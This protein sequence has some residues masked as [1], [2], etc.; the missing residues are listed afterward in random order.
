[1]TEKEDINNRVVKAGL[2]AISMR[3]S[4]R[5]LGVLSTLILVRI[6]IPED[7][8][9]VAMAMVV[10]GIATVLLEFGVNMAIIQNSNATKDFYNSAWTLRIFQSTVAAI[11]LALAAPLAEKYF[12]EPRIV[13]VLYVISFSVFIGGFENIG[14]VAFQKHLDFAKD[15]KFLVIKK[16]STVVITISLAFYL[17]SYWSLVIG[18]LSGSILGVGFSYVIS[19]Y[20]PRISFLE[21][22]NLWSF[23][24]WILIRNIGA[25]LQTK[26]DQI[27]I[28]NRFGSEAM[29]MYVVA[30]EIASTPTNEILAPVNR[31]LFP[32]FSIVKNDANKLKKLFS[33]AYG[34]QCGLAIP[35][36]CGLFMLAD[37]FVVVIMGESWLDAIPVMRV[38]S[39]I[40]VVLALRHSPSS[41]LTA[42]GKVKLIAIGVWLQLLFFLIL[43]VVVFPK[44][45]L[46]GIALIRLLM[47]SLQTIGFIGLII[48]NKVSSAIEIIKIIWRPV[49]SSLVMMGSLS[50]YQKYFME[51]TLL[52]LLL[53]V[54]L[55]AIFYSIT[56]F[57]SWYLAG[58]PEG[59]EEM[60]ILKYKKF[61]RGGI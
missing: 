13:D 49:L 16:I 23:S 43:C 40:G 27:I 21:M 31:A 28:G 52:N 38:L 4:I 46:V 50:I 19:S 60:L 35:M 11:L 1:M 32:A 14:I 55:G 9:I 42:I 8:G 57:M 22:R 39:L 41:L 47:S 7:F 6:L 58:K 59:I 12:N 29:G 37:E 45:G 34:L 56:L 53:Q 17:R 18:I 10:A 61:Q 15:F 36:G 25:F 24:Q 5:L 3:W 26:L 44:A 30:D 54:I 33:D 20:R 2:W 48:Q 51:A